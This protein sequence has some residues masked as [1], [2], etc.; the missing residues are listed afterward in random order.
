VDIS[1]SLKKRKR[2]QETVENLSFASIK[3]SQDNQVK[4]TIPERMNQ[5]D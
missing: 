3:D 1:E 4:K 5:Y 2:Q